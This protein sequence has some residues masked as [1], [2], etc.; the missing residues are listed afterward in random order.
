MLIKIR[1]VGGIAPMMDPTDLPDTMA[2]TAVNMRFDRQNLESFRGLDPA[3]VS[4]PAGTKS[5]YKYGTAWLTSSNA[6]VRFVDVAMTSDPFDYLA[7]T[8]DDYPRMTRNDI[9]TNSMPYPSAGYRLGVPQPEMVNLVPTV[10]RIDPQKTP[11]TDVDIPVTTVY[12]FSYVDGWGR[13]GALSQPTQRVEYYEGFDSVTIN[14]LISPVKNG[15]YTTGAKIRIYKL[16]PAS[17]IF[18][19]L[20]EVSAG[21]S[22]YTDTTTF[23]EL[24]EAPET[25]DWY[26]PPDDDNAVNPGGPLKNLVLMAGGFLLGSSGSEICASVPDVPHAWPYRQSLPYPVVGII[27]VDNSAVV[28]TTGPTYVIQGVDPAS[29][30]PTRI[31]TNQSCLSARSMVNIGGAVIYAAP[32]GLV[33]VSGYDAKLLTENLLTKEEWQSTFK[34]KEIHAYYYEGKYLF[35]NNSKG[36]IFSPG[37]G[38]ASLSELSFVATAGFNDLESDTL[39]LIVNGSLVKFDSGSTRLS[40]DWKSKKFRLD[41]ATNFAYA[42]LIAPSYPVTVTFSFTLMNNTVRTVNA[43]FN[44]ALPRNMPSGYVYSAFD[45]SISG[46]KVVRSIALAHS[47]SEFLSDNTSQQD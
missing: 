47:A 3:G 40:Y 39:Y 22:S 8:P 18:Q 43:T 4:I 16:N 10:N 35:F 45:V 21:V 38:Q 12:R 2:Q 41:T 30:Q 42:Q 26:P 11:D 25:E 1:P 6:T 7:Y 27:T 34:P 37:K 19:Y 36:W 17:N 23:D 14:T 5:L 9:A 32:D 46:D 29:L 13:E 28:A 31:N 24:G 20:D 33:G 15:H 44:N